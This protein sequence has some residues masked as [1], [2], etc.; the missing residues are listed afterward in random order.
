MSVGTMILHLIIIRIGVDETRSNKA[1][2]IL[3]DV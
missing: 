2:L 1:N 3:A